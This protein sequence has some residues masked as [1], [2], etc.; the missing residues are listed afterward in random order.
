MNKFHVKR[1]PLHPEDEIY[2]NQV[3]NMIEELC[4]E[5]TENRNRTHERYRERRLR[6]MDNQNVVSDP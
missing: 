3:R 1:H 5:R 6:R 2:Y 4:N